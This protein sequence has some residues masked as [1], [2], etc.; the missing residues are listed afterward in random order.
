MR[1]LWSSSNFKSI[2]SPQELMQEIAVESKKRFSI[3]QRQ[4]CASLFVWLLS[5]LSKE[6]S[7]SNGKNKHSSPVY[8]PFQV[9]LF[10]TDICS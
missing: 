5:T 2:V 8:D 1:K 10:H 7:T 3:G 4:E 6:T 9:C